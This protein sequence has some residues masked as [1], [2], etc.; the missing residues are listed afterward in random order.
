MLSCLIKFAFVSINLMLVTVLAQQQA[1]GI[2]FTPER[3]ILVNNSMFNNESVQGNSSITTCTNN[4]SMT[5]T[6]PSFQAALKIIKNN[7]IINI[8][9]DVV[10]LQ[11]IVHLSELNNI[12]IVG[13]NSTTVE[14]NNSG[15]LNCSSCNNI[16]VRGITWNKCGTYKN[17]VNTEFDQLS[18]YLYPGI[19]FSRS[20]NLLIQHCVFQNSTSSAVYL[21]E[22][23]G[24]IRIDH[25]QFLFN[26]PHSLSWGVV[27]NLKHV[28]MGLTIVQPN[29]IQTVTKQINISIIMCTFSHNSLTLDKLR[30]S[31][32]SST[33]LIHSNSISTNVDIVV[34]KS[35]FISNTILFSPQSYGKPEN[36]VN[37]KILQ[38]LNVASVVFSDITFE[39]NRVQLSDTSSILELFIVPKYFTYINIQM[40]SCNFIN[41]S[42][43]KVVH[44]Q[45]QSGFHT[46]IAPNHDQGSGYDVMQYGTNVSFNETDIN[47]TNVIDGCNFSFNVASKSVIYIKGINDAYSYN[48]EFII[49]NST[50]ENNLETAIYAMNHHVTFKQVV[51]FRNNIAENGAAIYLDF[52]SGIHFD[53]NSNVT[54]SNNFARKYGGAIFYDASQ[55]IRTCNTTY[56]PLQVEDNSMVSFSNNAAGI[57]GNSV[58]FSISHLCNISSLLDVVTGFNFSK[59]GALG[60]ELVT[61]PNELALYSPAVF[62]GNTNSIAIYKLNG[63]ML[64]QAITIPVCVLDYQKSPAGR[65]LFQ[66]TRVDFNQNY[67]LIASNFIS[68]SCESLGT[69]NIHVIGKPPEAVDNSSVT[70]QF[71]S[72]Y[73]S[74][75]NWRS[76]KIN[77]I[78]EL[79]PCRAGYFYDDELKQCVCYERRNV[80]SCLDGNAT[81][82][83]GYW[84]GMVNDQPTVTNCPVNYCN[85]KNCEIA[86][87]ICTLPPSLDEQ[88]M[89]HRT[90]PACGN[91]VEGYTLSF[92][93]VECINTNK[94]SVALTVF[95]VFIALIYWAVITLAVFGVMYFQVNI[96]YFYVITYFYSMLDILFEH[97]L[98]PI[99]HAFLYTLVAVMSGITKL[100]P[101]F[102]GQLCF[103]QGMSGIDQQIIHYM[104]PLAI[105]LVIAVVC[106]LAR[107]SRRMSTFLSRGIIR[108]ICLLILLSFTAG[109]SSTAL[110]IMRGFY[111]TDIDALYVYV[112]PDMLYFQGRHLVYSIVAYISTILIT[113]GLPAIL[114]SEPFLNRKINFTKLKPLL[115][116]FQGCYKDRLRWFASYYMICRQVILN[117]VFLSYDY[118]EPLSWLLFACIIINLIHWLVRPYSSKVLNIY[119]GL[120]LQ[121]MVS[122][123]ALQL[124]YINNFDSALPIAAA[125]VLVMLPIIMFLLMTLVLNAK[126]IKKYCISC[127]LKLTKPKQTDDAYDHD[128]TVIAREEYDTTVDHELRERST[129]YVYVVLV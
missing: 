73:K 28:A 117:I 39:S 78:I 46:V 112:S 20:T 77:L 66:V 128:D 55:F 61:S 37:I 116:Q 43:S 98:H 29:T 38:Y 68:I 56:M 127:R 33:L 92:D 26:G 16:T 84:F 63:I 50:F 75:M 64:G 3:F 31:S 15:V 48:D 70:I 100:T 14:C 94:C 125:Y 19:V 85:Y 18:T 81:I 83:K 5:Y 34:S 35:S 12:A 8:T 49:M 1:T 27:N 79:S 111:F 30:Y 2:N 52:G 99:N 10:F 86:T 69:S 119:D 71:A 91:C 102:I 24:N 114:L 104:H 44:F 96:A 93:S 21:S 59:T 103:I 40:K 105:W 110:M 6:C 76:I 115:D 62:M 123:I 13:Q 80:V 7:T 107:F 101:R 36:I 53:E 126:H 122:I 118:F 97:T 88:C 109:A 67:S 41:N 120:V 65:M 9:T 42:A 25:V 87:G 89:P 108:A 60:K 11:S 129:T 82:M 45:K 106:I 4:L 121:T 54:F 17:I 90:G 47:I 74:G 57:A 72:S 95:V 124:C 51:K 23:V 113:L 32:I 58:Y 22:V